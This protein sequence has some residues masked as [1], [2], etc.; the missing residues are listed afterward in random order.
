MAFSWAMTWGQGRPG[1]LPAL[2]EANHIKGIEGHGKCEPSPENVS[3]EHL[4]PGGWG[5]RWGADRP[6]IRASQA[7]LPG[8]RK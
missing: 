7:G 3:M 8:V 5:E 1:S 6:H 2:S 4:D